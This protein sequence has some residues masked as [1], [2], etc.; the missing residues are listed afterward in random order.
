MKNISSK[1]YRVKEKC[2]VHEN[3]YNYCLNHDIIVYGEVYV[4]KLK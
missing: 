2:I 1:K 3:F 4:G